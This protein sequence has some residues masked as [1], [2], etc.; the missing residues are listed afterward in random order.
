MHIQWVE[1]SVKGGISCPLG[2][3]TLIVGRSGSGK[4]AVIQSV[5]LAVRGRVSDISGRAEV[6]KEIDLMAL[7]P[8]RTGELFAQAKMSTGDLAVWRAGGKSKK[9]AHTY[10]ERLVDPETVLPL[11]PVHAAVVG[12]VETARK[13]FMQYA[14]GK[15][16]EKD[17]LDRIPSDLHDHYR[18]A[19]LGTLTTTSVADKLL[20]AL[21]KA[22]K[23]SKAAKD[24]VKGGKEVAAATA[25]GLAPLPT[26]ETQNA[27]HAEL[28]AARK[29]LDG[30]LA[31]EAAGGA[32][33]R[34]QTDLDTTRAQVL[35][36][37]EK[38][39]HLTATLAEAEARLASA[40]NAKAVD[41]DTLRL[42][43]AISWHVKNL[44][45]GGTC[46]CCGQVGVTA[47]AF[48][49]RLTAAQNYVA[50]EQARLSGITALV[51]ARDAAKLDLGTAQHD[52]AQLQTQESALAN[53]MASAGS[54]TPPTAEIITAART[55]VEAAEAAV[56]ALSQLRAAW[57][58]TEKARDTSREAE[59]EAESWK[60]L[61]DACVSAVSSLLD[62]GIS[63]FVT[64][65]QQCLPPT[66]A[67]ALTLRDG[68]RS[69]FQM[70][71]MRDSVLYTA[72]SGAEWARMM[73]AVAATCG[74][75]E[76]KLG[77]V[78]PE[79]RAFDP[80]TLRMA[81]EAFTHSPYQVII[82]S[83]TRP[84]VVPAG[85]TI[86]DTEKNE[87]RQTVA[88]LADMTAAPVTAAVQ[89]IETVATFGDS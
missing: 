17:V 71:F 39:A 56:D 44:P 8:G 10:P 19:I 51:A 85:W 27:L 62:T 45:A 79:E 68:A 77:V 75:G 11:R 57:G 42:V 55:R 36:A 22:K 5:E 28:K 66:D 9:A 84:D 4:S 1:S 88:S 3:K 43:S 38:V 54:G 35:K 59:K 76:G 2:E 50:S 41:D 14:V 70:G 20:S 67:F 29:A 25:N 89:T 63:G 82:G 33:A 64:R 52:L 81:C 69:V 40:G 48:Q 78:I 72:L 13:F 87:H 7:A 47:E 46:L 53:A 34:T 74:P 31:A 24:R 32:L 18:R 73:A 49:A 26:E 86:I 65:V 83:P 6:A 12:S 30:L 16:V 37:N 58:S 61:A 23:E 15:I 21:E 80:I 60:R